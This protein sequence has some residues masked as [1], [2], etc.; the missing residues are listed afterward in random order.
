MKISKSDFVKIQKE[1]ARKIPFR[2]SIESMF[3]LSTYQTMLQHELFQNEDEDEDE[4]NDKCVEPVRNGYWIKKGNRFVCSVC[5]YECTIDAL[6]AVA[7][8][9]EKLTRH[10]PDCGAKMDGEENKQ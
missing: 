5:E 7:C 8:N 10:C 3:A 9:G 4:E 2:L 1:V 6:Y